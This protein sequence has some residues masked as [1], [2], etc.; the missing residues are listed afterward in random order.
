MAAGQRPATVLVVD[1]DQGLRRLI[2]KSLAREGYLVHLAGT[3]RQTL[4]WL[5]GHSA[6]LALLDL[7]LHDMQAGELI[8]R[9]TAAGQRLPFIVITGQGDERVAVEMMKRGALD[10]LVKDATFLDLVP[11]VVRRALAQLERDRKLAEAEAER[12]R[13]ERE[14]LQIS[15]RERARIGQDLHDGLGQH[16]A[17]IE[18]LSEVLARKLAARRRPEAATAA[19]IARLVREAIGQTRQLARGLSPVH[20][21]AEGL[22]TALAELAANT[23]KRCGVRCA[24]ECAAPVLLPNHEA[25]THLFR[26]AQEAVTNALK[27]A[28]SKRLV[29]T[30]HQTP[31]E[32]T[33]RVKDF[34][35]GLPDRPPNAPGLGL[36]LMQ[37][38]ASLIGASLRVQSDPHGGTSV[39]C[40]LPAAGAAGPDWVTI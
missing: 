2:E 31:T 25:A 21:E 36:R 35:V 9:L 29:I 12:Q 7:K 28:R 8:E 4:D 10:Y 20:L 18:M 34:G 40:I 23:Q 38:R 16:L 5:A 15:D 39:T 17:G 14:I 22:M 13:L 6:D 37:H 32:T 33:L 1:D 11:E 27:H 26:I 19:E 30:L 24:F 3:G